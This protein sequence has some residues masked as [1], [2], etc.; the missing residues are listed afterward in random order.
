LNVVPASQTA[1]RGFR[2]L[3]DLEPCRRLASPSC[4]SA[5]TLRT[6]P[7]AV[8]A[9][10]GEPSAVDIVVIRAG[11]NDGSIGFAAAARAVILA[12]R[13]RGVRT[14]LWLSYSDGTGNQLVTYV[15][16]NATLYAMAASGLYPELV[17]ADWRSYASDSV[18]WYS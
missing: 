13:D 12:A 15:Q 8:Q 5:F 7:T 3:L 4:T 11:Y 6:P 14:V 1:L 18:G 10:N 17:V 16:H 2:P 9:I